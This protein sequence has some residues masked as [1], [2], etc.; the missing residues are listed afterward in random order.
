MSPNRSASGDLGRIAKG[1]RGGAIELLKLARE[2]L[3]IPAQLWLALAEIVGVAVLAVWRRAL[4]P[5]LLAALAALRA[6]YR[7]ALRH[8]R[9]VHGVIAVTAVAIVAL[10]ASQWVD[11]RGISVGTNA[12]SESVQM[13][14]PAPEVARERAGEAHSWV[15]LPLAA[16]AAVVA[17]IAIRGRRRLARL[18]IP[19]GLAVIAIAVFADAP[20]GLDE[21]AA[22]I[23]YE[24]AEARLLEG[25]WLQIVAGGVLVVCGLLLPRYLA[26]RDAEPAGG[27]APSRPGRGALRRAGSRL[28][29]GGD[30]VGGRGV[31][32]AST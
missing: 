19:I 26:A 15:M 30:G 12:Y 29:P 21:G 25:F 14:A 5:V 31:G 8:V 32:E 17:V 1:A 4:K 13:V 6:V 22:A 18:L 23:S 28:R 16:A 27:N 7:F 11:Y 3:V 9:P 2:M 20:K 24:G 10:A